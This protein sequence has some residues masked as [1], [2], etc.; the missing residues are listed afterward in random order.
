ME[1]VQQWDSQVFTVHDEMTPD[2]MTPRRDIPVT[3]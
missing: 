2:E 1:E 3:K